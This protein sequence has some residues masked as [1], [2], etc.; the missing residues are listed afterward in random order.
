MPGKPLTNLIFKM[1]GVQGPAG[2]VTLDMKMTFL[3]RTLARQSL[4]KLF[5]W[6]FDKLIIAH[7][8]CIESN[9]KQHL[10]TAFRGLEQ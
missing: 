4:E 8:E 10:R 5:A 1:G 9:A 6:D 7:G 2:G 3:N